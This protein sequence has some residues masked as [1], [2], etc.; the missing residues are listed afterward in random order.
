M[1]NNHV[2]ILCLLIS[3]IAISCQ[4]KQQETVSEEIEQIVDTGIL[5]ID[6]VPSRAQVHLDNEPKGET[7]LTLY[8]IPVGTYDLLIRKNGY[9]DFEKKVTIVVGRTEKVEARLAALETAV[10]EEKQEDK[11]PEEMPSKSAVTGINKIN[12]R[13]F[14]L[15]FDFDSK[16]FT[17]LRTDKS[18]LFTRKYENYLHLTAIA[19]S[20]IYVLDK[21]LKDASKEDCIFSF[22]AVASLYAGQTACIKTTEGAI[23]IAGW[24]TKPDELEWISLS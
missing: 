7:P 10:K 17:E 15:Y 13:S 11:N 14:A 5:L 1:K 3:L 4:A 22:E 6:S 20:Q 12:I 8:N 19:P 24:Q 18:D 9:K 23:I 2:V 21:S 16:Q